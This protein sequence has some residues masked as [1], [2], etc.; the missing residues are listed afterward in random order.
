MKNIKHIFSLG[1]ILLLVTGCSEDWLEL[2]NPNLQ[3][4]DTFWAKEDD[5]KRGVNATYQSLAI[6]DGTY[7][8]FAP[9]ALNLKSDDIW[10][11]SP[12]N[13][14]S[15]VGKFNVDY[16]D[17]IMQ[18]FLWTGF[19]GVISRANQV[20]Y[21]IED[22]EFED[23]AIKN[24]YKGE[25]L[26]LRGLAYFHLINFYKNI[27]LILQPYEALESEEEIFPMQEAPE[28]IW[29]QIYSDFDEASTL[30]PTVYPVTETGR[31]TKGAALGFLGRSYLYNNEYELAAQKFEEVIGLGIY[32][33]VDNYEDNFTERNE[34]NKESLFEI[35]FDRNVGGTTLGWV[36]APGPN[37]SLTSAHAITFAPTGFG[38]GDAA[39]TRWIFNLY[40]EE[41]TVEGELD[42][43]LFASINFDHERITMYGRQGIPLPFRQ[44]FEQNRWGE[45]SIR[46]YTNAYNP[47]RNDEYDWRSGINER[48]MRY[49]DILLMYAECKNEMNDRATAAE[50]IQMVRNRADLPNRTSEFSAMTQEQMRQQI[51]HE[52]A[53]EFSF[54]GIRFFDI[55]R[56]GWLNDPARLGELRSNDSE[57]Q[58]FV[59][60]R[61]YFPIPQGEMDRNPNYVQNTG[62]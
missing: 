41:K 12:W 11:P 48:L 27:P 30:L 50:Y 61:E 4:S 17:P 10:S 59:P 29:A 32:G 56:W 44:A 38:F 54:E 6:Y 60:G 20:L 45:I 26:F 58:S 8:R 31:A 5:F 28:T 24:Q 47:N 14:L 49:A 51:A 18:Q 46:K 2:S 9:F 25:A 1:L 37:W 52:R 33:L 42:P 36:S 40:H 62:W 34:N 19:Y 23:Q 35:Q 53:L 21:N 3:R 16:G 57:F 55:R 13:V 7:M 22:F 15:L 43:R 39:P